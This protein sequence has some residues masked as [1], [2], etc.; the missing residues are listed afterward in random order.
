MKPFRPG[1]SGEQVPVP[2]EPFLPLG[3][4]RPPASFLCGYFRKE[5]GGEEEGA[6]RSS[7]KV[8]GTPALYL[9]LASQSPAWAG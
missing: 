4:P 6:P 8:P 2:D 1:F 5:V 9:A 7:E 3:W